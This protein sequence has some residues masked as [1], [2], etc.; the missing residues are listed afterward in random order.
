MFAPLYHGATARVAGVRRQL[1]VQTVFNLLGPL[2][3]PAGAPRQIVGVWRSDL[4]ERL[5]RVLSM[6][7]S[8]SAWVVHGEDGLDEITISGKTIVA[9]AQSGSVKTFTIEPEDFGLTR[10][11]LEKLRGGD[12][13]VNAGIIGDVL[14]GRRTDEARSLVVANSAAA[15]LVGGLAKDLSVAARLAAKS[16]DEGAAR[17]K[18]DQLISM[19]NRVS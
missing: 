16:I 11:S 1:G 4:V 8:E 15:L 19:T 17:E 18:L 14:S 12:A 7:G 2:S 10:G 9:E 5:A 3:N 6:L 13:E